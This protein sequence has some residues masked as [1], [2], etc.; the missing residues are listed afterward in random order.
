[1][2]VLLAWL[3]L[4]VP[5]MAQDRTVATYGD[6]SMRCEN[7]PSRSCEAATILSLPDNRP[8]AQLILGQRNNQGPLLLLVVVPLNV[9]LPAQLRL[10]LGAAPLTL[11]YQRCT[12]QGCFAT[13]DLD[14]ATLTR[15]RAEPAGGRLIFQDQERREISASLSMRGF[16]Q[17]QAAL[18]ARR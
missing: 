1:M 7:A 9:H 16:T 12:P 4:M 18:A 5:A 11:A 14:D 15:L 8:V 2:R 17:A 3:L 6:W 13:M 10:M